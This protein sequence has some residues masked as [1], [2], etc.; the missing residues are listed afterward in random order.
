MFG[1][2][3]DGLDER[4]IALC[5]FV[6]RIPQ[7]WSGPSLNLAQA[8]AIVCS[9]LFQ[10]TL[11]PGTSPSEEYAPRSSVSRVI[12]RTARLARH[13]GL[14]IRN[15][16]E[17]LSDALSTTMHNCRYSLHDI[18]VFEQILSQVEWFTGLNT[19]PEGG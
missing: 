19:H 18:A 4:D 3:S 5:N 9:E 6:V 14:T 8:A 13:C 16:P 2:E 10:A 12:Q 7:Y 1:S 17:E 11:I 15:R